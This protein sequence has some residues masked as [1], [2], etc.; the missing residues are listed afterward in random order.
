M[1]TLTVKGDGPL[2]GLLRY[3]IP[4]LGVAGVLPSAPSDRIG[5]VVNSNAEFQTGIA[6]RNPESHD[7]TYEIRVIPPLAD[8]S[9]ADDYLAMGTVTLPPGGQVSAYASELVTCEVEGCFDG[10]SFTGVAVVSSDNGAVEAVAFEVGAG[11]FTVLPVV[12]VVGP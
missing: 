12:P 7:V 2:G 10:E 4:G 9:A 6:I 5:L 11:R 1:G 8:R 3:N